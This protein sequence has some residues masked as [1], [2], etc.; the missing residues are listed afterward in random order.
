MR[1]T[2]ACLCLFFL[3]VMAGELP[4]QEKTAREKPAETEYLECGVA[5]L[6]AQFVAARAVCRRAAC[7]VSRL[8]FRELGA[9]RL[10]PQGGRVQFSLGQR[11]RPGRHRNRRRFPAR[12]GGRRARG[13]LCGRQRPECHGLLDCGRQNSARPGQS[14]FVAAAGGRDVPR[15]RSK[16]ALSALCK[17]RRDRRVVR[18]ATGPRRFRACKRYIAHAV[19][20][21]LSTP[22]Q[23]WTCVLSVRAAASMFSS[24][25][26]T[27]AH[28]R[29][30]KPQ[31]GFTQS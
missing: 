4:A 11:Q 9:Q 20:K 17:R 15:G 28:V 7:T 21:P 3:S 10:W 1:V 5:A 14:L 18:R 19:G 8:A 29:V 23:L 30:F 26:R 12:R 27:S 25:G 2:T 16:T 24:A 22:V 6:R 31:S 13:P